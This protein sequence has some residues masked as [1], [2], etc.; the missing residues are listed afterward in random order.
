MIRV[1]I[2]LIFYFLLLLGIPSE[3]DTQSEVFLQDFESGSVLGILN[4]AYTTSSSIA[5]MLMWI[6]TAVLLRNYY[7]KSPHMK[8]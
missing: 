4:D 7:Y 6:A 5:F 2:T 8:Y 1:A 3:R